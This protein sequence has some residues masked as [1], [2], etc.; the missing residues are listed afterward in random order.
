MFLLRLCVGAKANVLHRFGFER[1]DAALLIF[2]KRWHFVFH[3]SV[4]FLS[5]LSSF[6]V[7]HN[8]YVQT[9]GRLLAAVV[10][11]DVRRLHYF[12]IIKSLKLSL[13]ITR[14]SAPYV[15]INVLGNF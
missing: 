2:L 13:S 3:F 11:H 15:S 9:N 8:G 7:A 1:K 12:I 14:L 6:R 4:H 5:V 10:S